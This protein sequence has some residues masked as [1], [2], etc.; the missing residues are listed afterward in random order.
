M[1]SIIIVLGSSGFIG[2]SLISKLKKN[3]IKFIGYNSTTCNLLNLEKT[4]RE[5]EKISES[6][7]LVIC[8]NI[9]RTTQDSKSSYN[10]N[11]LIVKNILRS[12]DKKKLKKLIFLSS[13]DVYGSKDDLR[14]NERTKTNPTSLYAKAKLKSENLITLFCKNI[15]YSILRLPGVY[16]PLDEHKS[17]I[18]LFLKKSLNDKKI[19]IFNQ[20]LDKRDYIYIDNLVTV[21]IKLYSNNF[22]GILNIVSGKS[23]S[24]LQI[25]KMI[26]KKHKSKIIFS[27]NKKT[28]LGNIYFDSYLFKSK[29][30]NLKIIDYKTGINKYLNYLKK[31]EK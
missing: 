3:K 22:N 12:I 10:K 29:F 7:Y 23:T 30:Q 13:V 27:D 4:K 26:S 14:I 20:G 19:T 31:N 16:G 1:G 21:I 15:P 5:F 18:G 8:S 28:S 11:I 24:I 9:K 6:Y 2:K 17:I 25:A